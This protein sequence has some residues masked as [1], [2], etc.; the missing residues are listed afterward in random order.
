MTTPESEDRS[1]IDEM[2]ECAALLDQ[3]EE[4]LKKT[5][6]GEAETH[7]DRSFV[8]SQLR[9]WALPMFRKM[10][11]IVNGVAEDLVEDVEGQVDEMSMRIDE[12]SALAR[13]TLATHGT[14]QLLAG[15]NVLCQRVLAADLG[16]ETQEM[17]HAMVE[18]TAPYAQAVEQME[19]AQASQQET[20]QE[21]AQTPQEGAE[22]PEGAPTSPDAEKPAEATSAP[23]GDA[24]DASA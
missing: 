8:R 9:N 19:V 10:L 17:L 14:V 5:E 22:A 16:D 20:S 12:I 2:D 13:A 23:P 15:V 7:P 1:V 21:A 3:W 18:A 6:P 11:G 24:E 4:R